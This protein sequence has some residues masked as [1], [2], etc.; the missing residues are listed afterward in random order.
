MAA[1]HRGRGRAAAACAG[2]TPQPWFPR[3]LTRSLNEGP[4]ARSADPRSSLSFAT[5]RLSS[6]C[7]PIYGSASR[8]KYAI[9]VL[10][11]GGRAKSWRSHDETVPYRFLP[12]QRKD[13]PSNRGIEHL[14]ELWAMCARVDPRSYDPAELGLGA[15]RRPTPLPRPPSPANEVVFGHVVPDLV[16]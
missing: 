15:G 1:T 5:P 14:A 12:F 8:A 6:G 13:A 11:L 7:S 16:Q 3:P 2:G 10:P 9:A 4:S